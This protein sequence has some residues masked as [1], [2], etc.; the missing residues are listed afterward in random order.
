MV[1][2]IVPQDARSFDL[3]GLHG[4][5]TCVRFRRHVLHGEADTCPPYSAKTPS[6]T[7]FRTACTR[8]VS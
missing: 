8:E 4:E 7:W 1:H 3:D 6:Q 2:L 5:R